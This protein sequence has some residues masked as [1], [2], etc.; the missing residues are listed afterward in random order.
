MKILIVHADYQSGPASGEN[1]VVNDEARLLEEA[2]HDVRRLTR[3]PLSSGVRGAVSSGADAVWSRSSMREISRLI[4]DD[5]PDV[6]HCH[7]VLTGISPA[8]IRAASRVQVPIVMTLHNYRM[9]CLPGTFLR[10]GGL[11]EACLGRLPVPGVRWR[12]YKGSLLASG[13][14]GSSIALHRSMG[15]FDRVTLFAAV[16]EFLRAKH[17]ESGVAERR[18]VVKPN[19]AWPAV[20][21]ERS[22]YFLFMGRLSPEK[23]VRTLIDAWRGVGAKL[24]VAGEGSEAPFL[25]SSAPR[26][27]EFLGS[28]D[29]EQ[30]LSLLCRTRALLVPS[31]WYEGA[32]RTILEAYAAGVPVLASKIGALPELVEEGESGLLLTPGDPEA[33]REGI[34][35]LEDET[36]A[37]SLGEGAH[38]LWHRHYRPDSALENLLQLYRRAGQIAKGDEG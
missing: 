31:L 32:P 1:Q 9:M 24:L 35:A 3:A 36:T 22:E 21:R 15:S 25:Q 29:H 5:R 27:V 37:G 20:R 23:G 12:C 28:V 8:I 7:N 26:N 10:D 33:W 19:F 4:R 18:I 13:V 34:I 38:E 11:C 17:I 6:V 30:A 16:S 14:L 2:G